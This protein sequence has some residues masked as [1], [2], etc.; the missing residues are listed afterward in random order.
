MIEELCHELNNWFD[1][2]TDGE[3]RRYFG[4]FTISD[5]AIDLSEL[6]IKDG[7]YF[8]IVGSVLNDGVYKYPA[9]ELTDEEFDGAVWLMAIPPEVIRL[10]EEIEAWITKYCGEDSQAASPYQSE[11]FGGYR[12]TKSSSISQS[13]SA[14]DAGSWQKAYQSRLNKWRKIIP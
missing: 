9:T 11:S 5:G 1:Q 3:K 14:G 8:R 13:E 2:T 7:Q 12:Y 6:G 10:A 4:D